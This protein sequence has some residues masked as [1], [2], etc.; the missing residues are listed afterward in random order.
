MAP[1]PLFFGTKQAATGMSGAMFLLERNDDYARL[2]LDRPEARNAI[3]ATG[4]AELAGKFGVVARSDVR[5]L[6]ITGAGRA[7]CAGADLGDFAAMRGDEAAV[8]RF[9]EDMRA[10]LDAL[11][12]LAMPTL[13]V[14][15]GACYGAGVALAIACD[16]RVAANVCE[17]A[18]TP[19]K[20]GISYPQ[21]DVHRLVTLIGPGH[22][23]RM[24]LTAGKVQGGEAVEIGLADYHGP[25]ESDVIE[26]IVANDPES[27]GI[28]KQ[29]IARAGAGVRSDPEMDARF[30]ALLAGETAARRLEAL[31]RK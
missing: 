16:I 15:E 4:W 2:T 6:V 18:I 9:R 28:L 21:E 12:A 25:V 31:R 10:A 24:L 23:A 20:I 1:R 26:A 19:A 29:A 14:V 3:P 27:L 7:F 30:D 5:L 13:A 11:R 8:A 17:F 22:A